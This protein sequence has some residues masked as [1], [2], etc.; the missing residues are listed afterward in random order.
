MRLDRRS[1]RS[2]KDGVSGR[3]LLGGGSQVR[4]KLL[5]SNTPA[6]PVRDISLSASV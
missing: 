5:L 6:N 3:E 1:R 4:A 2:V